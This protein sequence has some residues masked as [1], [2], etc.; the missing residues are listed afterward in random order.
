MCPHTP[1]MFLMPLLPLVDG[2]HVARTVFS[3]GF[4]LDCGIIQI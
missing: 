4:F 1:E 2:L 3:F